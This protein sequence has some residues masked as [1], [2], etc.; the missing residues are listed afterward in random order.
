[1]AT[2]RPFKAIRPAKKYADKVV[3]LPYDVM[4]RKEAAEM[5]ESNPYSF[6]HICRSEIDLPGEEDP[7][8]IAVYEKAKENIEKN[9]NE[10]IFV[11]EERPALY[12]Y[13]E[14]M[15]GRVQTGIVGCVAVDEYQNNTIKKH[16]FT[17]V[18]KEQDRINHFDICDADTEPVFLTY[19]DD[20][21]IRTIVEGVVS[22]SDPVYDL[23]ASDGVRHTLWIVE[24]ENVI[25]NITSLFKEIPA[26]YIADGHHRSASACKVGLKRREENP[27]YTGDEEF[28]FF[29]AAIFPD[30]DLKIFDY[31][32]VIKDLNGL[33]SDEFLE[34]IKDAGFH[35]EDKGHSIYHP[36]AKHV[37]SMYL[38]GKWYKLTADSSIIPD[39]VIDSLDVAI[40]QNNIF[41]PILGIKDQRTDK[42]IYF[43]GGIRGLEELEKRAESDM[44]IGFAVYPVD[45]SD[46]LKVS[47]NDMVMPPKSTWFEPKLAS[48]L[49]MHRLK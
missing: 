43:V 42:R 13:R 9:L 18:E 20:K 17:R 35:I 40:I 28:N 38:E 23:T 12:V 5:A 16:E 21:R 11:T 39:H 37:F 48:G 29:M 7:Y 3:S 27:G 25:E 33:S 34:R 26:L 22:G 6:L 45:V 32:R 24:D 2:V 49:F 44:K 36:E 4:N 46:L 30:N 31:N 47:D 19:R 15:D 41:G 1:M 14:V 8:D 10:G